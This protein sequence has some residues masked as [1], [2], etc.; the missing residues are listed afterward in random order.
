MNQFQ[1]L[2]V[3]VVVWL[4]PLTEGEVVGCTYLAAHRSYVH[5]LHSLSTA[6]FGIPL[7]HV[8]VYSGCVVHMCNP[9]ACFCAF[10]RMLEG[11]GTMY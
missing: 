9:G 11:I 1:E 5:V 6:R 3:V 8:M 2:L 7:Y 4:L 10:D